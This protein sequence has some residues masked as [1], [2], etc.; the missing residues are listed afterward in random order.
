MRKASSK[1]SIT[2]EATSESGIERT[3]QTP[4]QKLMSCDTFAAAATKLWY[5]RYHLDIFSF[6]PP[7]WP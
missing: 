4:Q 1:R 5:A 3:S 6:A 2:L 7:I